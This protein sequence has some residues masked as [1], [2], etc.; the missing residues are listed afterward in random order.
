MTTATHGPAPFVVVLVGPAHETPR[1]VSQAPVWPEV[2]ANRTAEVVRSGGLL[3]WADA[4]VIATGAPEP[5]WAVET[6]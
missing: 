6:S 1:T 3:P 4:S 2:A 5:R